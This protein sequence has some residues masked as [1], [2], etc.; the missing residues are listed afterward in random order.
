MN[1]KTL[2]F[3]A[4]S[5]GRLVPRYT[6]INAHAYVG[7]LR[8]SICLPQLCIIYTGCSPRTITHKITK[9]E[10]RKSLGMRLSASA[11]FTGKAGGARQSETLAS[12]RHPQTPLS[13]LYIATGS[14]H[15]CYNYKKH[16]MCHLHLREDSA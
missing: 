7:S 2:F 11:L 16:Y 9:I 3:S 14:K 1:S 6:H 5:R 10:R 4:Y 13:K 8:H 12:V 15:I